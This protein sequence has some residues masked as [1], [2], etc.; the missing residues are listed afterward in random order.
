MIAADKAEAD[1]WLVSVYRVNPDLKII[2]CFRHW[3]EW[4]MRMSVHGRTV[5][6]RQKMVAGRERAAGEVRMNPYAEPF[7]FS[8][9][10]RR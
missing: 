8:D 7:P 3:S 1:G 10:D 9:E 4:A 6:G 5:E 2:R